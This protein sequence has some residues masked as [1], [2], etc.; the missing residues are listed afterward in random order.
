MGSTSESRGRL[1]FTSAAERATLSMH[2]PLR[3]VLSQFTALLRVRAC[4]CNFLSDAA[5]GGEALAHFFYLSCVAVLAELIGNTSHACCSTQ[6]GTV[7]LE[8]LALSITVGLGL[9]AVSIWWRRAPTIVVTQVHQPSACTPGQVA[10]LTERPP[11]MGQLFIRVEGKTR[12]ID[13]VAS[14]HFVDSIKERLPGAERLLF[15]GKDLHDTSTL[16]ACGITK[17]ATIDV[18]GRLRGGGGTS[19]G[20]DSKKRVAEGTDVSAEQ[21]SR[22]KAARGASSSSDASCQTT[23]SDAEEGY[24]CPQPRRGRLRESTDLLFL[25][26]DALRVCFAEHA[27]GKDGASSPVMSKADLCTA[28]AEL[29]MSCSTDELDSLFEEMDLDHDGHIQLDEFLAAAKGSSHLEMLLQTLP[30]FRA[31]A[32]FLASGNKENPLAG[33]ENMSDFDVDESVD[34]CVPMLREI[35]KRN[36]QTLRE[37][38]HLGLAATSLQDLGSDKFTFPI[39]G[40]TLKDFNGGITARVGAPNPDIEA[41][42]RN[43]HLNS[44]DS[45]EEFTTGNYGITTTP[46]KEYELVISGGEGVDLDELASRGHGAARVLRPLYFYGEFD[47]SGKLRTAVETTPEVVVKAGLTRVEIVAVITYT[48]PMYWI[49]NTVLRGEE[50]TPSKHMHVWRRCKKANNY[51]SSVLHALASAIKKIQQSGHRLLEN[52]YLYRGLSGGKLPSNMYTP[53]EN[54]HLGMTEYGVS[55]TTSSLAVACQYSGVLSGKMATALAVQTG[56]VDSA[57][58]LEDFSQYPHEKEYLWLALSYLQLIKG[59][60]DIKMTKHGPVRILYVRINVNSKTLTIEELAD[61]RKDVVV[62]MI[63]LLHSAVCQDLHA[64]VL[65]PTFTTRVGAD[66][67]RSFKDLFI[68]SIEKESA[69]Q[70]AVYAS[71]AGVWFANNSQLGKAVAD[72]LALPSLA[73]GKLRLWL[74]DL[75]LDLQQAY[76]LNFQ[77]ARLR[78]LKRRERLLADDAEA[79]REPGALTVLALEECAARHYIDDEASLDQPDEVSGQTRL[80]MYSFLGDAAAVKRLLQARANVNAV[81]QD[82]ARGTMT[83]LWYAAQEGNADVVKLLVNF[84]ADLQACNK[85]QRTLLHWAAEKGDIKALKMMIEAGTDVTACDKMQ[86]TPFDLAAAKGDNEALQTLIKAGG[87]PD[88]TACD[89]AGHTALDRAVNERKK[90]CAAVLREHGGQHSLLYAA[91]SMRSIGGAL[92]ARI[93]AGDDVNARN[94]DQRTPLHVA[95]MYGT[96]D[97]V[98]QLADAKADLEACDTAQRTP[99]HWAAERDRDPGDGCVECLEQLAD[100]KADLEARDMEQRTPLHLAVLKG[101]MDAVR[102]LVSAKADLEA[103]DTDN[104]TPLALANKKEGVSDEDED[105]D[106]DLDMEDW[107]LSGPDPNKRKNKMA[108]VIDVLRELGAKEEEEKEEGKEDKRKSPQR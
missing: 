64:Q 60:E 49:L 78:G 105:E 45:H 103:R 89:K 15:A 97:A 14:H 81:T 100:A 39:K 38:R 4:V 31:F 104:N 36:L 55:S 3:R 26:D 76:H 35:F 7:T 61:Q 30:I 92:A 51:Y 10:R 20:D 25:D 75:S 41:G 43:E 77:T 32:N 68:A 91:A 69:A 16:D 29:K 84:N 90:E 93:A 40:G 107:A 72:G 50:A 42:V 85:G 67:F 27:T 13:N 65:L 5:A 44:A 53:D 56:Q 108:E 62:P 54:G 99:L 96:S 21:S 17:E 86:K 63:Q 101:K 66:R 59:K 58:N 98:R 1:P 18:V 80:T 19:G 70:V 87:G 28:L 37:A 102:S 46:A 12:V 79:A 106:Q 47:E 95:A 94:K 71:K 52:M 23:P 22:N 8:R 34:K 2:P 9:L 74:N 83:A 33:Y 48:G 88:V 82:S 6:W 57:A 11:W 73:Y 24:Y